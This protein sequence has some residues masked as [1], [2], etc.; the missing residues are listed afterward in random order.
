MSG[1]RDL[2]FNVMEHRFDI[3]QIRHFV[4]TQGLQFL[5]F[6]QLPPGTLDQFRQRYPEPASTRDLAAWHSFEQEHPQTFAN[7][8]LFWVQKTQSH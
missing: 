4:E 7:M 5:G 2:L 3:P 1:C 6:E 8:Y